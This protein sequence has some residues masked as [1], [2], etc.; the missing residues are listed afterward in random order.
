M[1]F[2]EPFE[3]SLEIVRASLEDVVAPQVLIGVTDDTELRVHFLSE[4]RK[5]LSIGVDLRDFRYD[6][7]NISLLEGAIAAVGPNGAQANG[8]RVAVSA[9]GLELLPHDKQSE[10]VKLLNAQRNRLGYARLVVLLWL[11]Q[12][13]Y[14]EVANKS[15]DFYSLSSHTFFLEPP[16]DWSEAQ[17]LESL[18]RSYL[19]AI[20]AQNEYVNMQGLAPMRGGQIVQ[21]RMDEIFIPLH[22]EREATWPWHHLELQAPPSSLGW[23]NAPLSS[24][25]WLNAPL[26][27]KY[28]KMFTQCYSAYDLGKTSYNLESGLFYLNRE[29]SLRNIYFL[30]SFRQRRTVVLGDPGAGKTTMLRYMAYQ[31]AKSLLNDEQGESE[32]A[33][34][35]ALLE[36]VTDYLP[37][38][39][40]I[41]LY[42]QHL[43]DKPDTD[44]ADFA[45]RGCQMLQ[46]PLS[47]ELLKAEMGR[48]RVLFLFD[49][50]DE[51]VDT[52][53]RRE[54]AKR[55]TEFASKFPDCPVIVTSRIVGY[56]EA[57]LGPQF[58]QFTI[59]PFGEDEINRFVE[60]WYRVLGEPHKAED[61]IEAIA[62]NDS[63]KRLASNPLLLTV[64]AL[65]H[66]RAKLPDERVK[67]YQLAA[68]TLADQWMTERRV[69]PE[70]WD[71]QE[72]I[73]DLLP[74]I[75]WHMH[76]TTSSGLI[77]EQELH[78]L[79]VET[80]R[81][82]QPRLTENEA[83]ARASQ[84]RR[85]V[86]EFSGIFLERGLDQEGQGLYGFLH[87]T[88]EEYFAAVRLCELW[89][90]NGNEVLKPLMHD[91][92]WNEIVLLAAGRFGDIS[93]YQATRFVRAILES[94]SELEDVLHRD[95]FLTARCLG[96]GVRV[97]RELRR[98]IVNRL[99]K[100]YFDSKS[101]S[102]LHVDIR[103]T[104]ALLGGTTACDDLMEILLERL[105]DADGERRAAA[106]YAIG[107]MGEKAAREEVIAALLER[108]S[109]AD[110]S[111]RHAAA[112]A[113]G[114]MGEKA[115]REE[116]IAALLERFSDADGFVSYVAAYATGDLGKEEVIAAL[117]ER[118]S[119]TNKHVRA[120]AV[121]ALGTMGEKAAR[122][123][124]IMALL[125]RLSDADEGVR[126]DAAHAIGLMGEKA[127][128][129]EV[130][131][132]LLQCL[133]DAGEG[134][135]FTAA[136]AIGLMGEKAAREEV[137]AALLERLSDASGDVRSAAAGA[138]GE[139]A[140][141]EEVIAA[142]LERLSGPDG[143]AR[144]AAARALEALG[145]K[146][147]RE[148]VIAAL[149]ERLSDASGDVR[150]AAA[151]ALGALG[152]K[153]AREEVIAALLERLSDAGGDVRSAAAKALG[154][155]GEKAAKEEVIAALLERLSDAGEDVRS[156]AAKALGELGLKVQA[157]TTLA[158]INL[159]L[160]H[161]R[162]KRRGNKSDSK[163]EAGYVA[164]RNLMSVRISEISEAA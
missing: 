163:R 96:D 144:T 76:C 39:V 86:A 34:A 136:H 7:Q 27:V 123:E 127:A 88:F 63:V 125:E 44:I 135:R 132:A 120:A 30:H 67:L 151:K 142:L 3:E 137:I 157:Q 50:L 49:G 26:E 91:P 149:L 71:A 129:E 114:L 164:L 62:G 99:C 1:D 2:S 103:N 154:A 23:L 97:D 90:R 146:A 81:R 55:V 89:E 25:G 72:T 92:R 42:A 43:Q 102:S 46:I 124:V 56:H 131:A 58:T 155:L 38:Y 145:E 40:R 147:A 32:Q 15:Y 53:E 9:I 115:A 121:V 80:M 33:R 100:L 37:V 156:A 18:R 11:N 4:L 98:E 75:A 105:S 52:S 24:L 108:L 95:L 77:G 87:L 8:R 28:A 153:A 78:K 41:G 13:L 17:R 117:L 5:K 36:D 83:N 70:A 19:Q 104:F 143:D 113:I 138:L 64:I 54:V 68:E 133:S 47:A 148:E 139:K 122:E 134:V 69:V 65:I 29:P 59:S 107:L 93:Q 118:M 60:N 14:A 16:A 22:V 116:V 161:A 21:M 79:L 162:N 57:Q 111:V 74:A 66:R 82:L 126:F 31:L 141:R 152:E 112:Y 106:A 158:F 94:G 73:R 110:E 85:N 6:P 101:P 20:I 45:P 140:A 109:D 160:P 61:L 150:S 48:G 51:I 35:P 130:I 10:A 159:M 84:F 128:R 12:K 119:D